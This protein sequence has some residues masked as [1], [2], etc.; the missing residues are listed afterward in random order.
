MRLGT[1]IFAPSRLGH[2]FLTTAYFLLITLATLTGQRPLSGQETEA[3]QPVDASRFKEVSDF[4]NQLKKLRTDLGAG[5]PRVQ[6]I[7]RDLKLLEE[8]LRMEQAFSE[9]LAAQSKVSEDELRERQKADWEKLQSVQAAVNQQADGAI[10]SPETIEALERQALTELQRIE[11]E[12]ASDGSGNSGADQPN[13][14]QADELRVKALQLNR[15]LAKLRLDVARER[16]S[17]SKGPGTAAQDKLVTQMASL[18][19][20]IAEANLQASEVELTAKKQLAKDLPAEQMKRLN[21]RR[22]VVEKQLKALP[23]KKELARQIAQSQQSSDLLAQQIRDLEMQ[24]IQH[25]SKS[26]ELNEL[27]EIVRQTLASKS[28][29]KLAPKSID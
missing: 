7:V 23:S 16:Q 14:F 21:D 5:H 11:W 26:T 4:L 10:A 22:A 12:L 25:Q 28:P 27:L 2:R 24:R 15:D 3:P 17:N 8:E 18:E 20:G 19:L 9:R 29:P 1:F 6:E 13:A